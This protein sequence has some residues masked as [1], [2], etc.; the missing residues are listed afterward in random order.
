ML[1]QFNGPLLVGAIMIAL[2]AGSAVA[3]EPTPTPQPGD[4]APAA[5]FTDWIV[6]DPGVR[7]LSDLRGEVVLVTVFDV[8]CPQCHARLA[9]LQALVARFGDKGLHVIGIEPDGEAAASVMPGAAVAFGTPDLPV[10]TG[11]DAF[12]PADLSPCAW[13][14]DVAGKIAWVG[15]ADRA[16]RAVSQALRAVKYPGLFRSE[17]HRDVRRAA[18]EFGRGDLADA[19]DEA[20]EVLADEGADAQ[21]HE[22]AQAV[23]D[24]VAAKIAARSAEAKAAEAEKRYPAAIRV[25]EWFADVFA[26]EPEAD[27]AEAALAA[28]EADEAVQAEIRAAE[29]VN[30]VMS[31]LA[32]KPFGSVANALNTVAQHGRVTGRAAAQRALA[33]AASAQRANQAAQQRQQQQQQQR[34]QQRNNRNP[35]GPPA[36]GGPPRGPGGPGGGGGNGGGGNGG[37][38]VIR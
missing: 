23:L 8:Y 22:D 2:T 33:A 20:R 27:T 26:G 25:W 35:G 30:T 24:A 28:Y 4:D 32:G 3:A 38:G 21:A 1:R 36:P 31:R 10:A 12:D 11:V 15:P 13:V 17:V 16:A 18:A 9:S 5:A 6:N 7:S 29:I 37:G 19:R 34:R 14:I